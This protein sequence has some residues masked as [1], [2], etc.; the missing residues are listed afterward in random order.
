MP[1]LYVVATPI[2]N[3]ED[4]TLRALRILREVGLI[5]AEDTRRTRRLLSHYDIK[6]PMTSFYE[7]SKLTKLD[8]ILNFLENKDVAI[9]SEAGMPGISDPGYELITAAIDREIPVVPVP[10]PSAVVTALAVS[11]LPAERFT[12]IG[13]LPRKQ[14]DRRK[15]LE[16]VAAEPGV[17][18]AFETPHRTQAALADILSVLGDRRIAVCREL[19]KLHEEI[20][21]GTVSGAMAYFTG[22]RGEFT[23]IIEGNREKEKPPEVKDIKER[24][25][26]LVSEGAS[27]REAVA[28][29]AEETG[30]SRKELYRLF[31][32]IKN[33]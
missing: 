30:V 31:L 3:L 12:Y 22:P 1:S 13:F 16:S 17:I 19:T 29:L 25:A 6:T 10:G 7:H 23:L 18:V 2:G 15:Q 4:I 9:V 20:Y 21:R 24:V 28:A 5:A 33:K 8:Y 32:E 26:A 27:A 14:G 11:G